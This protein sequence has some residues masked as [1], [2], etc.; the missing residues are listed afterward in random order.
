MLK[1]SFC[2]AR[3]FLPILA[4]PCYTDVPCA[5]FSTTPAKN[6]KIKSPGE[7]SA[8]SASYLRLCYPVG[9]WADMGGARVE[10][11]RRATLQGAT[12]Q[13]RWFPPLTSHP[14]RKTKVGHRA[15]FKVSDIGTNKGEAVG[16]D[17][18][19]VQK[20]RSAANLPITGKQIAN[21]GNYTEIR[22]NQRHPGKIIKEFLKKTKNI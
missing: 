21:L 8:H 19:F 3:D 14:A 20:Q 2:C 12:I 4:D 5:A 11:P 1:T 13:R 17:V 6:S 9:G 15:G 18:F 10:L 16:G 22:R 7:A